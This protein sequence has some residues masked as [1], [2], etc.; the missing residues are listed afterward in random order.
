MFESAKRKQGIKSKK[1]TRLI[2][3]VKLK[4]LFAK[5]LRGFR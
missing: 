1:E 2:F 5:T 3:P 4:Y